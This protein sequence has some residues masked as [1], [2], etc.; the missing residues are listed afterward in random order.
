M[1]HSKIKL[2]NRSK[3]KSTSLYIEENQYLMSLPRMVEEGN[4]R[5]YYPDSV[6]WLFFKKINSLRSVVRY[7]IQVISKWRWLRKTWKLMHRGEF[8]DAIVIGNGP[9]QGYLDVMSLLDFKANG[10]EVICVNFWMDNEYICEVIPTYLVISDPLTLS[11]SVPD[12]IKDKNE[13]LLSYLLINASVIIVCPLERC[14]QLSA[15]FGNERILGFVDQELRMWTRNINPMYPRGYLSMTLYKALAVAI[16]F[17]YRKIYIIG[18]DNTYPRNIYC[19]QDNKVINHEIHAGDNDILAD[20]SAIF[21]SV[22]D[23]LTEVAQLFH[24][25][26]KFKNDKILNLDPYS[27]TDVFKKTKQPID[28]ISVVLNFDN[29]SMGD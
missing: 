16:W 26:Q 21:S 28:K 12:Y 3:K 5:K 1:S 8:L 25:L 4:I 23:A 29:N 18:M 27:L 6:L 13:R 24:D 22:G 15:I 19:D 10:G 17:N 11:L 14:E 20:Q 2:N 7:F 9:S